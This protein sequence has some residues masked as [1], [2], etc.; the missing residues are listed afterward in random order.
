VRAAAL[1]GV[2]RVG[3]AQVRADGDGPRRGD[4]ARVGRCCSRW[5]TLWRVPATPRRRSGRIASPPS[6]P[7]V[8]EWPSSLRM[9]HSDTEVA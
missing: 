9:R 2:A 6:S 1:A 5:A 8:P 3:R 7:N 4:G